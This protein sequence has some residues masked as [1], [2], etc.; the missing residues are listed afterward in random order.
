MGSDVL[1]LLWVR[2]PRRNR[3]HRAEVA[4]QRGQLL[5]LRRLDKHQIVPAYE[6]DSNTP[7]VAPLYVRDAAKKLSVLY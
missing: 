5:R 6:V 1:E 7:V 2:E 4:Y 3:L